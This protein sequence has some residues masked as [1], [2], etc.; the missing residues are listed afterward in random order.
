MSTTYAVTGATGQLGQLVVTELLRRGVAPADVVAVVRDAKKAAALV[1]AGV[2][3]RVGNYDQ[4]EALRTALT[5]VDRLLLIS[6]SAVGQRAAQ[7]RNVIDAA[8]H[9]GVARIVYTSLLRADTNT[10]PLGEEHRVTEQLLQDSGLPAVVLRN[11][12]YVE[13]YT[14]QL[15]G[16]QAMAA[17]IGATG[18]ALVAPA[19]RSDYAAAAAVALL[20]DDTDNAVHE[21]SGAAVSLPELAAALSDVTGS[22]LPYKDVSLEEYRAGLLAAG[23]DEATAAFVTALEA[24][25]AN[26]ELDGDP[27]VL[28]GL[29]GRPVTELRTAMAAAIGR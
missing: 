26:G 28:E 1:A 24:G 10:M 16:Y 14:D 13:N 5:G 18:G 2:Q 9:E 25:A 8:K 4:P 12:W 17:V 19:P 20:D 11:G 3:V 27:T 21:L 7:H 23:L 22:E 15:G 29:L 6:G